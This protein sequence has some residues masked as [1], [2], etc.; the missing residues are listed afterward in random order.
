MQQTITEK[1][2][3]DILYT[4]KTI[5][6]ELLDCNPTNLSIISR[7]KT[8]NSGKLDLLCLYESELWL[9]ELKVVPFYSLIIKQINGYQND[10]IGLQEQHKI[11]SGTIKKIVCVTN[12]TS[13]DIQTC[14]NENIELRIYRP[15]YV[16]EKYFE[17]FREGSAF[18]K[19]QPADFGVVRLGL[20]NSTLSLLSE[21]KNI[22]EIARIEG[23][24]PKTIR[25]RFQ[26]Y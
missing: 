18:I 8:L 10:L 17:N 4:D 12:A 1:T 15:E 6:A 14:L 22:A 3:E 11:I 26:L 25:N 7:Q 9:V 13:V 19:I 20:L 2:I 5:L 16:L 21:G 23:R 24:S